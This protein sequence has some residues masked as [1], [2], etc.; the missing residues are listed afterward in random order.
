MWEMA[1]GD[2]NQ[3]TGEQVWI[4]TLLLFEIWTIDL[5][6]CAQRIMWKLMGGWITIFL[7]T[8]NWLGRHAN[9]GGEGLRAGEDKRRSGSMATGWVISSPSHP[10]VEKARP[11]GSKGRRRPLPAANRGAPP[12]QQR[13]AKLQYTFFPTGQIMQLV[14]TQN[15]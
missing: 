3:E 8:A 2:E 7:G 11:S 15:W 14:P 9:F 1:D 6:H 10:A 13:A 5:S 12:Q 4:C